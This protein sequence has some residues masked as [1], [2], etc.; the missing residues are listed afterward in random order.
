M[1]AWSACTRTQVLVATPALA[2]PPRV[3]IRRVVHYGLALSLAAY[4]RQARCAGRDGSAAE[5]VMFVGSKYAQPHSTPARRSRHA[6][7]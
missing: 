6:K 1:R 2:S 4:Y 3:D 7:M 5:C